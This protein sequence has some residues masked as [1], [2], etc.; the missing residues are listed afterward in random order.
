MAGK[1]TFKE[2]K[3]LALVTALGNADDGVIDGADEWLENEFVH[4]LLRLQR[5]LPSTCRNC[6]E[7]YSR[8]D[9]VISGQIAYGK[10]P[11]EARPREFRLVD[12]ESVGAGEGH[13]P[14]LA[15]RSHSWDD[16]HLIERGLKRPDFAT[17]SVDRT[18]QDFWIWPAL[19]ER[20][21]LNIRYRA[22]RSDWEPDQRTSFKHEHARAV[23]L[24]LR[25]AIMAQLQGDPAGALV[26]DDPGVSGAGQYQLA[27][28]SLRT[29][30]DLQA[31]N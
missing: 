2:F 3:R 17:Y 25:A 24:A 21:L 1:K 16:R 23:G 4:Q 15:E 11:E 6:V 5:V 9:L 14:G 19:D 18:E 7:T 22:P 12:S 29:G 20:T 13:A 8:D 27:V 30:R 28:A 31:C 10:L 26:F